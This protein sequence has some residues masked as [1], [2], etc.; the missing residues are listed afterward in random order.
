MLNL[1]DVEIFL[2]KFQ[3]FRTTTFIRKRLQCFPVKFAKFL[4]PPFFYR[5]P[6]MFASIDQCLWCYTIFTDA[7]AWKKNNL[8]TTVTILDKL[9]ILA[10]RESVQIRS[11]FW[12]VF[13]HIRTEYGE[14]LRTRKNS[15]FGHFSRSV[16]HI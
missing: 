1:F 16:K 7:K 11:F 9:S 3:A 14:I 10:Q 13:S 8:T 5:I 12:S 15:V 4:R 6:P 2:I